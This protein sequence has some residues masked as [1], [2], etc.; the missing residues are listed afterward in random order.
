[1]I[2]VEGG[3]KKIKLENNFQQKPI[4]TQFFGPPQVSSKVGWRLADL[5]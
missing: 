5:Q 2:Q 1:M 3:R 4:A